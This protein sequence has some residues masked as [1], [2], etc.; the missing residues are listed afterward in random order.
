MDP[1]QVRYANFS[2]KGL[3]RDAYNVELYQINAPDWFDA[4]CYDVTAKLPDGATK[5]QIPAMMKTLL[6]EGFRMKAHAE[7]RQDRVCA[8]VVAKNG[9]H[10][11]ESKTQSDWPRGFEGHADGRLVF[12]STTLDSFSRAMSILVA[13]PILNMTEIQ[14]RFDIT[15]NVAREDLAGLSFPPDGAAD[16]PHENNSSSSVF[17]AMQELGLRLESRNA[18]IPHIVVDSAEKVPTGN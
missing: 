11:K 15:L 4:Q 3:V 10:L 12:A 18:P 1:Q 9:P 5:E 7:T 17:A 8:L 6:A 13:R 14:G 2:L 16:T